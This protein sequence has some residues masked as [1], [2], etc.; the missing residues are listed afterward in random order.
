LLKAFASDAEYL[1]NYSV[2]ETWVEK[3]K[4]DRWLLTSRVTSSARAD[5]AQIRVDEEEK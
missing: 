2:S 3:L 5:W 4:G 1:C